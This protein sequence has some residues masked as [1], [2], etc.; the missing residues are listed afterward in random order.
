MKVYTKIK[1]SAEVGRSQNIR[2]ASQ[3]NMSIFFGALESAEIPSESIEMIT[4][5]IQETYP[6]FPFVLTTISYQD[7]DVGKAILETCYSYGQLGKIIAKAKVSTE[8][9]NKFLEYLI[10]GMNLNDA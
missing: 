10:Q 4:E 3:K 5:Q 9:E 7:P 2:E 6:H 8:Q 1:M